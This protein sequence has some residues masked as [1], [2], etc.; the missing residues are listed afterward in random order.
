M[1]ARQSFASSFKL[2]IRVRNATN[3]SFVYF[4]RHNVPSSI[5]SLINS[6]ICFYIRRIHL[7]VQRNFEVQFG[8]STFAGARWGWRRRRKSNKRSRDEKRRGRGLRAGRTSG[9]QDGC[10]AIC[11]L[12]TLRAQMGLESPRRAHRRWNEIR[13]TEVEAG[14]MCS[15]GKKREKHEDE[16]GARPFSPW[17]PTTKS[18]PASQKAHRRQV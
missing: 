6:L 12:V 3:S 5:C 4:P 17:R 16:N 10:I 11:W 15:G 14:F 1:N 2:R 8:S 13:G 7:A 18:R 9:R